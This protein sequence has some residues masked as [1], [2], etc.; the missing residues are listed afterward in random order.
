LTSSQ[1]STTQQVF[2]RQVR[3]LR[4][5]RGLQVFGA[6][7]AGS[8]HATGSQA[9]TSSQHFTAQQVFGRQVRALRQRRG[10]QV[11]GA[12][13]AGSQ[14]CGAHVAGV[15]AWGATQAAGA[16]QLSPSRLALALETLATATKAATANAG[17]NI[18][19]SMGGTPSLGKT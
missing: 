5:R 16:Q 14:A 2:G 8:Q 13:V 9:L 6:H 10:L 17:N 1:H 4:Q 15:Q 19:R 12:H 7:V 18:R 3:A 11:F